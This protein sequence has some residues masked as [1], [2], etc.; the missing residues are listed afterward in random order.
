MPGTA[1]GPA[2]GAPATRTAIA[3]TA[4]A[5]AKTES[6]REAADAAVNGSLGWVP[7]FGTLYNGLSLVQD[8]VEFFSSA[9]TR[10]DVADVLDEI[11]DMTKDVIGM[12]P[13]IGGPI[14][15]LVYHVLTAVSTPVNHLPNAVTDNYTMNEDTSL[16][17]N[18]LANDTDATATPP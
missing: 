13:V 9:V 3:S 15:A 5:V 12:V 1:V 7:V 16:T 11:G 17:N 18:L 10:G 6:E 2:T 4:R 14:A 8:F